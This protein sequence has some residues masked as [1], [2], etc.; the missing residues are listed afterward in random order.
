MEIK[1]WNGEYEASER[2]GVRTVSGTEE[3]AQRVAMKLTAR[4][5]QF[6]PKPDYGSRLYR[7]TGSAG[8]ADRESTVRQYVAEALADEPE[9]RLSS[10]SVE[11]I[12]ADSMR[13]RL[14]FDHT[15][16]SFSVETRI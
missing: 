8:A 16:D 3:L 14:G 2:G 12:D 5:G 11:I 7:L 1:V 9:V 6:W 13:L 15:G 4:R 10:V